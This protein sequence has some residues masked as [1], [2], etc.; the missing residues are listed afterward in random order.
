MRSISLSNH[1]KRCDNNQVVQLGM[2][3]GNIGGVEG[4][5]TEQGTRGGILVV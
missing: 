5:T 2:S 4:T 1:L 3:L